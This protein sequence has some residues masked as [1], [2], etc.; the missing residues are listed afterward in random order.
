MIDYAPQPHRQQDHHAAEYAQGV[1]LFRD[2]RNCMEQQRL[3]AGKDILP[4]RVVHQ[5]VDDQDSREREYG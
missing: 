1:F 5:R 2:Q 4:E 3:V